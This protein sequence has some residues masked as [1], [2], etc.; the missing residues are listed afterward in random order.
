MSFKEQVKKDINQTFIN[1]LEMASAYI[2][3]GRT[4]YGVLTQDGFEKKFSRTASDYA[5]NISLHGAMFTCSS[6]N[7]KRDPIRGEAW[8]I[9]GQKFIVDDVQNKMG[10]HTVMLIKNTGR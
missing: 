10:V 9:D 1:P 2:I 8:T 5:E 7:F 6:E 3:N 4:I